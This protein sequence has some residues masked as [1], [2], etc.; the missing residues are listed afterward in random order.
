M[1]TNRK[2][3]GHTCTRDCL[4]KVSSHFKIA[5]S[6]KRGF[7]DMHTL[8]A[9]CHLTHWLKPVTISVLLTYSR[10]LYDWMIH[11][12]STGKI[13][14]FF[15][16]FFLWRENSV[17]ASYNFVQVLDVFYLLLQFRNMFFDRHK[18][19]REIGKAFYVSIFL[20]QSL[21]GRILKN[22][23]TAIKKKLKINKQ[24]NK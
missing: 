23:T 24:M 14:L 9:Y 8:L 22:A 10:K 1:T 18:P 16:H 5:S 13:H 6:V 3:C 21:N 17:T 12:I 4:R 19:L 20:R 2:E 11:T 7:Q 15:S